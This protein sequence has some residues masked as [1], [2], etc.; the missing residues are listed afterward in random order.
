MGA[1]PIWNGQGK[2]IR[3]DEAP[4]SADNVLEDSLFTVRTGEG[5]EHLGLIELVTRLLTT[6]DVGAFPRL[7]AEQRGYFW[8][9]LVRVAA[10]ALKT[11]ELSVQS[12]RS[13]QA[14]SLESRLLKALLEHTQLTDWNLY[15]ADRS[16]PAFLQVSLQP[17]KSLKELNYREEDCSLLT[18]IIGTKGHERKAAVARRLHAEDTVYALIEY[19][20]GTIFG[21]RGN[22]ESQLTGSRSGAGSGTPFMGGRVGNSLS[23]T[24]LSDVQILLERWQPIVEE[25]GLKGSIWAVWREPWDGDAQ[26]LSTRLDPAF[27]PLA[28]MVR[29]GAP[30]SGRYS[31]LWFRP[32]SKSRV[33]D[34]TD[35]GRLGDIFTPT[36][37]DPSKGHRK[38]R[39]TLE[40]GYDYVETFNLLFGEGGTQRSDSVSGLVASPPASEDIFVVFEGL[41]LSQGKTLGFHR[42]EIRL[43]KGFVMRGFTRVQARVDVLH[44]TML[45][46]TQDAK[47]VLRGAFGVLWRGKPQV[48]D[49]DRQKLDAIADQL[50]RYVDGVYIETLLNASATDESLEVATRSYRQSLFDIVTNDIFPAAVNSVPRSAARE[51]EALTR[52]E[53]YLRGGLRRVLSLQTTSNVSE[54]AS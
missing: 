5:Q 12:A 36:V 23:L 19:Q 16:K 47:R 20:T 6:D 4:H 29:L 27:I 8:R 9:F 54:E 3:H 17:G 38:V 18:A 30:V 44:E 28:R 40:K 42:R 11:A 48:R 24:F 35:G 49:N 13:E 21:G 39:G 22:Y 41:A 32:S 25:I 46:A 43:P 15:Q 53:A 10:R 37:T 50:D 7:S 2:A 34:H 1:I 26:I 14:T 52:S 45:K 31:S 33:H 51:M